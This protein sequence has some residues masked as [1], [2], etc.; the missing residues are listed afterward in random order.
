MEKWLPCPGFENTHMISSCGKL[1]KLDRVV[2]TNKHGG[3]K[4]IPQS[5]VPPQKNS[6][7]YTRYEIFIDYIKSRVFAHRL[8]ALAFI[9]NPENKP[10]VNHKDGNKQNNTV[11]NLEW[12]TKSENELHSW[13]VLGKTRKKKTYV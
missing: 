5:F 9:S 4:T 13:R 10:F 6:N 12:C 8:V 7:G 3:V 11:E 2:K 1:L